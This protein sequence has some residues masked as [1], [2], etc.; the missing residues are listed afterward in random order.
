MYMLNK[1]SF[2]KAEMVYINDVMHNPNF[3]CA[4]RERKNTDKIS[5]FTW[6]LLYHEFSRKGQLKWIEM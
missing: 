3:V 1:Q 2:K 6:K 4:I 5:M